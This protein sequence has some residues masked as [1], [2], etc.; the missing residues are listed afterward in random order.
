MREEGEAGKKKSKAKEMSYAFGNNKGDNKGT[1]DLSKT[2]LLVS[3]HD[4]IYYSL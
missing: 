1:T 2:K 3:S 4:Y